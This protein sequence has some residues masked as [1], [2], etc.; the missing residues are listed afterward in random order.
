MGF[1]PEQTRPT[2]NIGERP[3]AGRPNNYTSQFVV[4]A[5]G[6]RQSE[7]VETDPHRI[8]QRQKQIDYGKN[9]LGY[10]RYIEEVPRYL[11]RKINTPITKHPDTPDV[12]QICSKR[13]FDGQA[14]KWRR[15]LHL[16]DPEDEDD[17]I[18]PV[19]QNA[20]H[21]NVAP[22]NLDQPTLAQQASA[23][24]DAAQQ[25]MAESVE[26]PEASGA[27]M[28]AYSPSPTSMPH[29]TLSP[30][31][32]EAGPSSFVSPKKQKTE[33]GHARPIPPRH[34]GSVV[35]ENVPVSD[36][37][38]KPVSTGSKRSY[39]DMDKEVAGGAQALQQSHRKVEAY[40]IQQ[41]ED[42]SADIMTPEGLHTSVND[43]GNKLADDIFG[44]AHEFD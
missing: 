28:S 35:G 38:R 43:G 19:M 3:G 1:V 12:H 18:E 41:E 16:W 34:G 30:H 31:S 9:T 44:P 33:A 2:R 22:A 20:A 6:T 5:S 39:Q 10:Q 15:E 40:G 7:V 36:P 25:N 26:S 29:Q 23:L 14:K 37:L 27:G 13:S 4:D 8:A 42:A 21:L 32:E 11:R 24:R 17:L